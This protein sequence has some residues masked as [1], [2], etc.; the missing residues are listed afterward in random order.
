MGTEELIKESELVQIGE[1]IVECLKENFDLAEGNHYTVVM[2]KSKKG[3]RV[4]SLNKT[5]VYTFKVLEVDRIKN[6]YGFEG[7]KGE[8]SA[9]F[10]INRKHRRSS[11]GSFWVP[12]SEKF[13]FM[14]DALTHKIQF[15]SKFDAYFMDKFN[16]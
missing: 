5:I 1:S 7:L 3:F 12:S 4:S 13:T 6:Q 11:K 8:Y 2:M 14:G 9:C 16:Q 15:L 10:S